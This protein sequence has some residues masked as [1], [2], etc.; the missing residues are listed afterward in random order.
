MEISAGHVQPHRTFDIEQL[1]GGFSPCVGLRASRLIALL[2]IY[3]YLGGPIPPPRIHYLF[4][5]STSIW[6]T[7][8]ECTHIFYRFYDL[9]TQLYWCQSWGY[10][11]SI[12]YPEPIL[13]LV[14]LLF[15]YIGSAF[16]AIKRHRVLMWAF[17][18]WFL[19]VPHILAS[20][21]HVAMVVGIV[22]C[23]SAIENLDTVSGRVIVDSN[24]LEYKIV[25][26][27]NECE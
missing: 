15:F 21:N 6:H 17:Y 26:S 4:G 18:L 16:Q 23:I 8:L 2:P 10:V 13:S 1:S 11:Y 20:S 24:W 12:S 5:N 25:L 3:L 22:G 14:L 9:V 27:I 7:P 19:I